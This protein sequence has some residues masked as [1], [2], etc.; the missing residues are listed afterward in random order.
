MV[1]FIPGRVADAES[2]F[3]VAYWSCKVDGGTVVQGFI[4]IIPSQIGEKTPNADPGS[5]AG[6]AALDGSGRADKIERNASV[7][8]EVPRKVVSQS[9]SPVVNA[10][11]AAVASFESRS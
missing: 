8:S 2:F 5:S 7:N 4:G 9:R 11:V 6:V 3:L 1:R 10:T